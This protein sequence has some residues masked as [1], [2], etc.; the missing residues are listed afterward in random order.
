MSSSPEEAAQLTALSSSTFYA[1]RDKAE[2]SEWLKRR[3][4]ANAFV[5]Q[6]RPCSAFN[7]EGTILTLA[8]GSNVIYWNAKGPPSQESLDKI[9]AEIRRQVEVTRGT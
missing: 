1:G 4:A 5:G 2:L 7:P 9:L 8:V 3:T 6:E